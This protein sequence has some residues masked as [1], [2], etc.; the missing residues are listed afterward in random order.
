MD[1]KTLVNI[2][3]EEGRKLIEELDSY[4]EITSAF[5]YYLSEIQEWRLILAT[6]S[7]DKLGRKKT[8]SIIWD[9]LNK[10]KEMLSIPLDAISIM[11]P[12][13]ELNKL[14]SYAIKTGKGISG[15]RF[16]GNVIN[17]TLIEDAY[18]YRVN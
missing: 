2:D 11:S 4:L 8:Y 1:K 16:S 17:G 14:L 6:P 10:N 15:I 7:I 3:I 12:K 5:W 13:Q 9:V 18:L